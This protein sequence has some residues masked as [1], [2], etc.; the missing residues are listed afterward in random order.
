MLGVVGVRLQPD[1]GALGLIRVERIRVIVIV[2][3][4]VIVPAIVIVV[5]HRDVVG[6]HLEHE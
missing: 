5:V 4:V 6:R 3:V 2:V 1:S